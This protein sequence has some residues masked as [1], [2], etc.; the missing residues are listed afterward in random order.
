[1]TIH[2]IQGD[3]FKNAYNVQAFGHGCNCQGVMGAGIAKEFHKR[4]PQMYEEYRRRC[5]VEPRQFNLGDVFFWKEDNQPAVFNLATQEHYIRAKADYTAIKKS[6]SEMKA[7][8]V[9][10]GISTIA[11]PR[12]GAG[13]GGLSWDKIKAPGIR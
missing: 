7:Q 2:Y 3:I 8:A 9:E 13:L 5:K 4:Y 1:V 12:I 6:L 11:I 10:H